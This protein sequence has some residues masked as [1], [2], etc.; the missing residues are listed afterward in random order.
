MIQER[1]NGPWKPD[2][3]KRGT[4][5]EKTEV[6]EVKQK[7]GRGG[8]KLDKRKN[9]A[10]IRCD[11]T[12]HVIFQRGGN[13][14]FIFGSKPHRCTVGQGGSKEPD[15]QIPMVVIQPNRNWG[16]S[17]EKLMEVK[18]ELEKL[19]MTQWH[20]LNKCG[21]ECQYLPGLCTNTKMS[22][23]KT[24]VEELIELFVKNSIKKFQR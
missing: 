2:Q 22:Q 13:H 17:K 1:C 9:I 16:V 12:S 24:K 14:S 5:T 6:E 18:E 11:G 3:Q 4:R 15:N 10:V 23:L 8:A 7:K 20:N 19:R 21:M